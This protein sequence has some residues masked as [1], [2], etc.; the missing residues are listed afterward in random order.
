[1]AQEFTDLDEVNRD[2][3]RV[4]TG[5]KEWYM[6]LR[7]KDAIVA[8][9]P[10]LPHDVIAG[11]LATAWN[12][13]VVS[14]DKLIGKPPHSFRKDSHGIVVTGYSDKY[15]EEAWSEVVGVQK[16]KAQREIKIQAKIR[17][18]SHSNPENGILVLSSGRPH[19][20]IFDS[21]LPWFNG[22]FGIEQG[23]WELRKEE[24]VFKLI[25][26]KVM[27]LISQNTRW[28]DTNRESNVF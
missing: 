25:N 17:S 15:A 12:Y 14:T 22:P 1:M 27:G 8:L 10:D 16:D 13:E 5:I 18:Y 11:E 19:P 2:S 23:V 3:I 24:G 20:S 9:T 28:V 7:D 21:L 6:R 26:I 4:T